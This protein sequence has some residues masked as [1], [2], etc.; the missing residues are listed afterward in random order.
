VVPHC[1]L[2][3]RRWDAEEGV[4]PDAGV[5][6]AAADPPFAAGIGSGDHNGVAP[7]HVGDGLFQ[8]SEGGRPPALR[9]VEIFKRVR[10]MD[11]R[12]GG[13]HRA[14]RCLNA[15]RVPVIHR[16]PQRLQQRLV[17]IVKRRIGYHSRAEAIAAPSAIDASFA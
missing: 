17:G 15:G 14:E 11:C 16:R 1:G 13:E 3:L 12:I 4:A 8:W 6:A 9:T 5:V 2:S 7:L 10:Q